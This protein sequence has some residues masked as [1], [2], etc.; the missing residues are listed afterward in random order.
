M[1]N[2]TTPKK[3]KNYFDDDEI[4][5]YYDKNEKST[6][7]M[8]NKR[9]KRKMLETRTETKNKNIYTKLQMDNI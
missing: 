9:N 8:T 6:A 7:A 2:L 4:Y 5:I 3:N 1:T